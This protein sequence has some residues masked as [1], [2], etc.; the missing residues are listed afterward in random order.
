MSHWSGFGKSVSQVQAY[1]ES[2]KPYKKS[3]KVK[4]DL[5]GLA[6]LLDFIQEIEHI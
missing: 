3:F 1:L 5:D 4:H 6:S 2:K